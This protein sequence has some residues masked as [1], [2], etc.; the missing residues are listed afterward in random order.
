VLLSLFLHPGPPFSNQAQETTTAGKEKVSVVDV[1]PLTVANLRGHK[2]LY[3]EGWYVVTSS[4][5]ALD[6]AKEKS[7]V[8]SKTALKQVM[9]EASK[10][11]TAYGVK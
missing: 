9:A 2:M 7:L 4:S 3:N 6:Y 8:S 11:T 1:I 10:D 5:K